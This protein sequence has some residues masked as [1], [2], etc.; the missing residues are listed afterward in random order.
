[1]KGPATKARPWVAR[2]DRAGAELRFHLNAAE[3]RE[4]NSV[5]YS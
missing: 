1:M 4:L 3:S 2:V 5:R